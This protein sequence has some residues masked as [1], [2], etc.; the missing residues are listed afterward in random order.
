MP[1]DG[2]VKAVSASSNPIRPDH[3][4]DVRL[5]VAALTEE[6]RK[7]YDPERQPQLD[8]NPSKLRCA[9]RDAP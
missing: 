2:S 4:R 8:T 7:Q 5:A 9:D 6:R 3:R 1:A